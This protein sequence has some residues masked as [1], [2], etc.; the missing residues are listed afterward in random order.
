VESVRSWLHRQLACPRDRE[1][2]D[3]SGESLVCTR[4]HRFPVVDG[5]PVLLSD[6]LPATHPY[7]DESL[8]LAADAEVASPSRSTS[9]SLTAIDP[10]VQDEIVKTNGNLYR[11]LLGRLPRYPI[12]ELRLTPGNGRHLLDV[13]CNWGRWTFAAARAGYLSVGI[14]PSL[15][16]VLAGQRVA[17][18]LGLDV[19]FVACDARQLP[20]RDGTLDASFS[21]SVLQ[22]FDKA[23]ARTALAEISRVTT[24]GGTV[25]VQMPNVF[26]I[27]QA[28]NSLRQRMRHD[29]TPFRV[30]YWRPA[31]LRRTFESLVG[32]SHLLV[33][34]FFSL[35]AQATDIDLLPWKHASVVRVSEV[36]RAA[37]RRL[38]ALA[39]VADSL[40]VC[41]ENAWAFRSPRPQPE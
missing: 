29:A 22:H 10:F 28:Y 19:A 31:E 13:G 9:A 4:G 5:I 32:P 2:L 39:R 25:L 40:Y 23:D 17:A 1:P 14:D 20:F 26:G 24:P 36:L 41:S 33:D 35:N 3:R 15:E 16:A 8:R 38:P 12:P 18:R 30:R 34:G 27:R 37:S 11:H 7:R 21:Y 6:D